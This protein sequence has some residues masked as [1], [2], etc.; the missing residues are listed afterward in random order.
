MCAKFFLSRDCFIRTSFDS[1]MFLC[2]LADMEEYTKF[3]N[4][5]DQYDYDVL[6][7]FKCM[8]MLNGDKVYEYDDTAIYVNTARDYFQLA[9]EICYLGTF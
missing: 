3:V 1:R 5:N 8:V 7:Y 9:T 2:G 4:S 6:T